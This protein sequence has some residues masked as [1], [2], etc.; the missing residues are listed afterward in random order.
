MKTEVDF[1][2]AVAKYLDHRNVLWFHPANE[3]KTTKHIGSL[4]KQQG[5]KA[6]VPDVFVLQGNHAYY[7]LMME[8]KLKPNKPT[9]HQQ[10]WLKELNDYSY[11]GRWVDDLDSAL[12]LINRYLNGGL[13]PIMSH[14]KHPYYYFC[15][16]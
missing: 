10:Q 16:D 5:V 4:L 8:L 13:I 12:H 14:R 7:G 1:Q 6:G 2:K 9:K 15:Q 11:C 3:R